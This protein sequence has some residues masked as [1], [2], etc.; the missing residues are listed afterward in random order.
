MRTKIEKDGKILGYVIK[1]TH[2]EY[3]GAKLASSKAFREAVESGAFFRAKIHQVM[4][5][6]GLWDDK[7]EQELQEIAKKIKENVNKLK[8]GGIKK[9]EGKKLALEVQKL[10][11]E[12]ALLLTETRQQDAFTIEGQAENASFD[13]L[14]SVCTV[15]EEENKIFKNLEDYKNR[16][17]EDIAFLAAKELYNILYGDNSW[18]KELPE[19]KFLLEHKFVDA[20]L[21]LVNSEGQH[22]TYDNQLLDEKGRLVNSSG[23][24]IDREGNEIDENGNLLNAQPFLD[25]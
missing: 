20:D 21:K 5:D 16:A 15:D 1:P 9:S 19:N 12:Q 24:L 25:D 3:A 13:Y 14:V 17:E 6:Q 4:I 2:K 22:V 18:E 8:L 23:K 7:K 11:M 10:R